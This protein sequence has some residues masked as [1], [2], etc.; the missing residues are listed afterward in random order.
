MLMTHMRELYIYDL[1]WTYSPRMGY[2]YWT[3][4]SALIRYESEKIQP[5]SSTSANMEQPT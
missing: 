5:I 4:T 2:A 1:T 3:C